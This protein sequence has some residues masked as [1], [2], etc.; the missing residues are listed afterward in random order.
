MEVNWSQEEDWDNQDGNTEAGAP[1]KTARKHV[2]SGEAM[3]V[4]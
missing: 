1:P 2:V 4:H 3:R